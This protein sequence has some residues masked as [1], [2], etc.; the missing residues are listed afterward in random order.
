MKYHICDAKKKDYP[1]LI[2]IW[3][4]SVRATHDFL[5]EEEITE[6]KPKVLDTYFDA[7]LLRCSRNKEGHVVGFIGL[8]NDKIEMLFVSPEVQGQGIGTA[9]CKD[10]IEHYGIAKVGVNEQNHRAKVFYEKLGFKTISRSELD[11]QGKPYPILHM[12]K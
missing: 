11:E 6:L 7:T 8:L 3:E 12:K 5:P 4:K 1:F 2:E 10:A 9:L